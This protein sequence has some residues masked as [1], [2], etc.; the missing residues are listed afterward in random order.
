MS[1]DDLIGH[2]SGSLSQPTHHRAG[3][4]SS[5]T[6]PTSV[7]HHPSAPPSRP[8]TNGVPIPRPPSQLYRPVHNTLS[9]S[10]TPLSHSPSSADSPSP[11]P[12]S[13]VTSTNPASYISANT[14]ITSPGSSESWTIHNA[15]VASQ[16]LTYPSVP[17]PSLASSVG[18]P[19]AS[20][21]NQN[22]PG[23]A[24]HSPIESTTSSRRDSLARRGS[25]SRPAEVGSLRG[26]NA[27]GSTGHRASVERGGRVA[28]TGTL[29]P[30]SRAGSHSIASSN[31]TEAPST[32]NRVRGFRVGGFRIGF[33]DSEN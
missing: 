7:I 1:V 10:N 27:S 12:F 3:S 13:P 25:A 4:L 33:F 17:P 23:M 5:A 26:G 22:Q 6:S 21:L 14:N 19:S 11:F 16:T 2:S 29:M 28:E 32:N 15:M 24:S 31:T 8:V 30:R 18:S 9:E 20:T